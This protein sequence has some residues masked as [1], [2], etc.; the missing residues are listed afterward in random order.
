MRRKS[1]M[2]VL[3]L[4]LLAGLS[5]VAWA[6]QP[7]NGEFLRGRVIA[8]QGEALQVET[9]EG[10]VEVLAGPEASLLVPTANKHPPSPEDIRIGAYI[11]AEGKRDEGG[12]FSA[13]TLAVV[14]N[15]RFR[16]HFLLGRITAIEGT[17]LRIGDNGRPL[18]TDEHT[19]FYIGLSY[20]KEVD[21]EALSVGDLVLAVH[22]PLTTAGLG[23][24]CHHLAKAVIVV[25]KPE[26]RHHL[27]YGWVS[28]VGD[29]TMTIATRRGEREVIT[30]PDTRFRIPGVRKPTL[31]DIEKVRF[32][33]L[34]V[35]E[36]TPDGFVARRVIAVPMP[37][38]LAVTH[39]QVKVIEGE[40]LVLETP[41]GERTVITDE[42]THFRVGDEESFPMNVRIGDEVVALGSLKDA[43]LLAK[44]VVVAPE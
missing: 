24:H 27:V 41:F 19:R 37:Q 6:F 1:L 4:G 21:I 30:T 3:L 11:V 20:P 33:A 43:A 18:F 9:L 31:D 16:S 10:R 25:S 28:A 23:G 36:W 44:L 29:E 14:P 8:V 22:I 17:T 13:E 15:K 5:Q 26:L 40:R 2:V 42:R 32:D 12:T 38:D 7:D 35:G 34:I 39:G